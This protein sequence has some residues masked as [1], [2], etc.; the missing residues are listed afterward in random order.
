EDGIRDATVTGVQ[1]CALPIFIVARPSPHGSP[2]GALRGLLLGV[3]PLATA[4]RSMPVAPP[5]GVL[6]DPA[7]P[8]CIT[9]STGSSRSRPTVK[10]GR[11]SCRER[12]E[13]EEMIGGE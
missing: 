2:G 7:Q 13:R 1:T 9:S 10:I 6:L 4:S 3:S 12:G 8:A 5:P 11:A